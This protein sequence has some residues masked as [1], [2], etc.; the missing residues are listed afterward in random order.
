[1]PTENPAQNLKNAQALMSEFNADD[2]RITPHENT[3][4]GRQEFF[5]FNVKTSETSWEDPAPT[6]KPI[7]KDFVIGEYTPSVPEAAVLPDVA[8]RTGK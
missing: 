5:Y 8:T 1:M 7:Y 3:Q 4:A 2:W 6:G